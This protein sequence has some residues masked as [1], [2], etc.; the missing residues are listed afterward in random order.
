MLLLISM[1]ATGAYIFKTLDARN[2][3]TSSQI[4]CILKD[5]KGF[6]WFGTPS[7]LYRYDGYV[8]KNFQS[9]SRDG[10]SLPDSYIESI[11]EAF[12]GTLW[13][14]TEIGYCVYHPQSETFERD[15]RQVLARMGINGEPDVIYIDTRNDMW[16]S[17]PGRGVFAYD[18]QQQLLYEFAYT[19]DSRGIPQGNIVSI[20]ECH[21]GAVFVYDDLTL[22]CC[23]IKHQQR[24][25]WINNEAA[26][27]G[28][29]KT[30]TLKAFA[31]QMDNI[32]VYG[33]GTLMIYSK[34]TGTWNYSIGEQFG[35]TGVG[36]DRS[37]NAIAGDH[38]GNIWIGTDNLGL[39][40]M[41]V[42]NHTPEFVRPRSINERTGSSAEAEAVGIH[43]LYVDD[44]DLL[45]VGTERQGVAYY[46]KNIYKFDSKL[47]GDVSAITQTA[48]STLWYG[49]SN[50]GIVGYEGPLASLKIS[51]LETTPDGSLWVGYKNNGLS[52]LKNGATSF[53]SVAKDSMRTLIND[54]VNDLCKDKTGNLWIATNGG[55]QVF[56]PRMNAFSSYTKENGKLKTNITTCLFYGSNN[57]MFIGTNEGLIILN[58]STTEQVILTG[59]RTNLETFTNNY[60]SQ[61]MEDSRGLVWVGTREGL[62]ILNM[63]N[64]KLSQ[65]TEKDGLCNNNICGITEDKNHNIWITTSN[66]VCRIV[67]QRDHV[68][69]EYNFGLYNYSIYDG[70]QSNEFNPGAIFITNSGDVIMGG[71]YGVNAVKHQ[72]KNEK[73]SLPKVMLTQLMVGEE[74]ILTG[75]S[76]DG[77]VILP[78]ALNESSHIE[79]NNSQNTFTIKFA[80]GNYNQGERLQFMYLM[81]GYDDRWHNGD[82]L[83]H[84]VT[85]ENLPSGDYVLHVKAINGDGDISN[86]ERTLHITINSPWWLS[87]WMICFYAIVILVSLYMWKFG[88]DKILGIWK[89]KKTVID[90]LKIQREEIKQTSED[91]R[92]PMARMTTIIGNL[93]ETEQTV[94]AQEQ[95]NALHFQML[96]IITRLTE[97]QS[98]LE[99][100]V[101]KAENSANTRMELAGTDDGSIAIDG[102]ELTSLRPRVRKDSITLQYVIAFVD[103]NREFTK[104]V[105]KHLE[106]IYNIHIYNDIATLLKDIGHLKPNIIICKQDMPGMTGS[107][108]CNKLKSDPATDGIKFVLVTD[109]VMSQTE[110]QDQNITVAAD[111]M[112]SK[113]FNVQETVMRINKLLGLAPTESLQDVIEG[114]ETR[115]LEERNSSMTTATISYG[116]IR[117]NDAEALHQD[118][119]LRHHADDATANK[120]DSETNL[121][122]MYYGEKTIGDYSM[123]NDMEQRLMKNMEQYVIQNMSRGA[124]SLED[125]ASAMGMGRVPLFHKIRTITNKTPAEYVR[126]LRLRH[127]CTLLERT[128]VNMSELAINIGFQTADNFINIFKEKY[129][130]TP[131]EY[132]MKFRKG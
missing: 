119:E 2:G 96:Q 81:E 130:I 3:L 31:D 99:N 9:N 84:G 44:T 48:D 50:K 53:Y 111:D 66:G 29:R 20:N 8:F 63:Q 41:N 82:A 67:A 12:D 70:L 65:I 126:D 55:L 35:M 131:L 95:L 34:K 11:Q 10:S 57:N 80:A 83:T 22:A 26:K 6:V 23:D 109:H 52:R 102:T 17:V 105:K 45:W 43:S 94:E 124:I 118:D 132:R 7:G 106:V 54:N 25:L 14:K 93:S 127:A 42:N 112:L 87:W 90:E 30:N 60:I 27:K 61:V 46:G 77:L 69:G 79:L 68:S 33:Q 38:N 1:A 129:G 13:V 101:A 114:S 28:L 19:N 125:L 71:L 21:D 88:I 78:Q 59:N 4:N 18:M 121:H 89:R 100:P 56:N 74:E 115:R 51:A 64:D 91:L 92:Q 98:T 39:I 113:P 76:Y 107:E 32:W 120:D 123:S 116:E 15:M 36:V 24:T 49:T 75:H 128:D 97:M 110:Q 73:A 37:V 103:D 85:F 47:I 86:Q 5:K 117:A 62:N 108:L 58:L 122:N 16:L 104:I 40:R 72:Q